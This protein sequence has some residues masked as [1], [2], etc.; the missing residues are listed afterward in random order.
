MTR[1]KIPF[2]ETSPG[3]DLNIAFLLTPLWWVLGLNIFIYQ[4]I[5]FWVLIK[6]FLYK[7]REGSQLKCNMISVFYLL[8]LISYL[9]SVLLN[10]PG[11][12]FRRTLASLN[13]FLILAMG[14]NIFLV[15]D[16]MQLSEYKLA[17]QNFLKVA[18]KIG[19]ISAIFFFLSLLLW[20]IGKRDIET[21]SLLGQIMPKLLE[22]PYSRALLKIIIAESDPLLYWELPRITIYNNV[23]TFAGG[24]A[25]MITPLVIAAA[26]LKNNKLR[27]IDYLIIV[28]LLGLV[29]S[30][31]SRTIFFVLFFSFY[32]IK[33]LSSKRKILYIIAFIFIIICII[34]YLN[35]I[36]EIIDALRPG[37]AAT[38][39][40]IY[41]EAA[42]ITLSENP[43][44][45][46][47]VKP[48]ES[49]AAT[50][51]VGSHSQIMAVFL[52]AGMVGTFIYLLYQLSVFFHLLILRINIKNS[53]SYDL[54]KCFCFAFVSSSLWFLTDNLDSIPVIAFLY[55]MIVALILNLPI[56]EQ[57]LLR[58]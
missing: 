17:L 20:V 56:K 39:T 23:N 15:Y 11:N 53:L 42:H 1:I 33:G 47:G 34:P 28:L 8:F 50:V 9:L 26:K 41:K 21:A 16:N 14:F 43:F 57:L 55:F 12:D 52:V 40:E 36:F 51:I 5:T 27:L 19:L 32:F 7:S 6:L 44:L 22:I 4:F 30:S 58:S 46:V 54:W 29:I 13:N 45:G 25:L 18:W 37:S 10:L 48:R 24:F 35:N 31:F 49:E 2:I 38:R 3:E